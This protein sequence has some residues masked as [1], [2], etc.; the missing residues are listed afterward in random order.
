[1]IQLLKQDEM[2]AIEAKS[3]AQHIAFSP[4]IFQATVA[5]KELGIL[6]FIDKHRRNGVLLSD[7]VDA[8]KVT[9][10][11][12]SV[13]LDFALTCG[14]VT[15]LTRKEHDD[16][17][18]KSKQKRLPR[19]TLT[20][21]AFFLLHDEMS[22]I[23]FDFTQH[24]GYQGLANLTESIKTGKPEGLKVFG[25]WSTLYPHL[26]ELP[27]K[28]RESWFSFDHFYSDHAFD[29][30]LP[31]VFEANPK[32][33]VDIGGNTGRFTTKCLQHNSEVQMTIMDL[34]P[35][36][37]KAN[38]NITAAG[39]SDRFTQFPCDMLDPNQALA[40]NADIYWMS[41]FLDCFSEPQIKTILTNIANGISGHQRVFILETF[42][43]AQKF[44]AAAFSLNATSLYFTCF[45]NGNSRMYAADKLIALVEAS[46]L[47]IEKRIDNIGLG[48]SLLVCSK[49]SI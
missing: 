25:D 19:Y 43:D 18:E 13:L 35:Q 36:L 45:A 49:A 48:H 47:A 8:V 46:G 42:W 12:V 20:K 3:M 30:I 2:S 1:M 24:F 4:F 29:E 15:I 14:L 33:I 22:V 9:E 44:D 11:G 26:A 38:Q 23:N 5:M 31:V 27:D 32:H 34:P 39:F 40:E 17:D 10:Y 16:G 7:I 6:Q 28:I 37:A 21:V 41:Q